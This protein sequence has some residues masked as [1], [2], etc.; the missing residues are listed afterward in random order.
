[1]GLY[2]I[3]IKSLKRVYIKH[4]A[5]RGKTK[6]TF[7]PLFM[8]HPLVYKKWTSSWGSR[9]HRPYYML[10]EK[11]SI[12]KNFGHATPMLGSV[13]YKMYQQFLFHL[14]NKYYIK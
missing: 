4:S 2:F 3:E 9:F 1:M 14:I 13:L 6:L 12:I 8:Q 5:E 10:S 7:L 11:L